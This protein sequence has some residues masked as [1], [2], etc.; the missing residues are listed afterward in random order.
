MDKELGMFVGFLA[1]LIGSGTWFVIRS[2]AA[3][4]RIKAEVARR[5]A[6]AAKPPT[7]WVGISVYEG[8]D[9]AAADAAFKAMQ[10]QQHTLPGNRE[11]MQ[12]DSHVL[13]ERGEPKFF[14][15]V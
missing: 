14:R 11:M 1:V 8:P 2:R 6:E 7:Y 10:N 12:G 15:V 3:Q 4:R 13:D 5:K 9:R